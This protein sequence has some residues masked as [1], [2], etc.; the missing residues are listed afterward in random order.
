M[1]GQE[2]YFYYKRLNVSLN[3]KEEKELIDIPNDRSL[4]LMYKKMPLRN[5]LAKTY[6][7]KR[8][9]TTDLYTATTV[10]LVKKTRQFWDMN[11]FT[12]FRFFF[13]EIKLFILLPSVL[14]RPDQL[15]G[16]RSNK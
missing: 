3:W 11:I 13:S 16:S 7:K 15:W 4:Q 14:S 5:F 1:L 12:F 10:T 9:K 6:V 8:L 2:I